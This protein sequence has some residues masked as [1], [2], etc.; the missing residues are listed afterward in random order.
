MTVEE[1]I[2]TYR[3]L[4]WLSKS[5]ILGYRFCQHLF[6]LRY[7][8]GQDYGGSL[9]AETGTNMHVLYKKFFDQID[10]E[11]LDSFV[12]SYI[13]EIEDTN[14]F[15]Y[16]FKIVM[17]LIPIASRAFKPYQVMV[18]NFAL[19]EADH[20]ITLNREYKENRSKVLK[21]FLPLNREKYNECPILQIFGTIDRKA[22]WG[23]D[24]DV[25]ILYDYKTGH[26]PNDVKAGKKTDNNF[27][28]TIP[29]KKSFELHFYLVLEMC[30]AGYTIHPDLVD[31]CTNEKWFYLD[32]ELP[33]VKDIFFTTNKKKESVPVNPRNFYR[34]GIIY[35]GGDKPYVPKKYPSK[36]SFDSVF[37]WINKIRTVIKM[38]GP[39]NKEP[40][41]WKCR[42]CN[43]VVRDKCLNEQ[44]KKMIFWGTKDE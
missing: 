24:K 33:K 43:S 17:E 22:L 29:T 31:F 6:D 25:I 21:Y 26:I 5:T 16:F 7:N 38:N 15:K 13:Q 1:D 18:K 12:L 10:Y 34:L 39:F 19:L 20:W 44:E 37:R 35:T 32:A 23:N 27:S 41:Y 30:S 2:Y 4:P 42:E 11:I 40:T 8:R 9:K 36:K 14:V 3:A 28:W